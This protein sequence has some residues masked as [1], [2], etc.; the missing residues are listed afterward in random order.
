ME[1]RIGIANTAKELAFES[2]L[3]AQEIEAMIQSA[4]SDNAAFLTFTDIKTRKYLVPLASVLYI[5]YGAAA[6]RKA[7]FIN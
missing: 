7:G 3:S 1:V 6:Q 5:E 2:T 4:Y